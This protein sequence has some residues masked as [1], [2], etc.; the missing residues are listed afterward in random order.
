MVKSWRMSYL[1][2]YFLA[3]LGTG[4]AFEDIP[5]CYKELQTN[6]FRYD[7]T[8][9]AFSLHRIG[10]S[11]WQ[12]LVSQLEQRSKVVPQL[13]EAEAKQ[14]NPNPLERPFQ[15]ENAVEILRRALFL[16]FRQVLLENYALL[17]T[18][19][20]AIREM[21]EHIWFNQQGALV[22]CLGPAAAS[23]ERVTE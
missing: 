23:K 7:L 17:V 3:Y 15:I 18:N 4:Y 6:F 9:Q 21:F 13:V 12:T 1:L 20:V 8:S 19:E 2:I 11:Q 14:L 10:Q 5:P 16:V 22:K